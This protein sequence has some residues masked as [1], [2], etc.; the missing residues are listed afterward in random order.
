LGGCGSGG[1]TTGAASGGDSESEITRVAK[2]WAHAY[3]TADPSY[4][5]FEPDK[6]QKLCRHFLAGG[7]PTVYQTGY[8]NAGVAEIDFTGQ[9][10]G[11]VTLTNGCEI[12]V[13]NESEGDWRVTNSGGSLAR[14]C[15]QG[16]GR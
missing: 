16:T 8:L 12:E 14:N 15:E 6:N 7:T 13:A 1:E 3:A 9:Q 11:L 5:D 4:C 10:K 2:L